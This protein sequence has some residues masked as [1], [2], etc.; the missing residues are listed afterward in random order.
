MGQRKQIGNPAESAMGELNGEEIQ[1]IGHW[2]EHR[3]SDMQDRKKTANSHI[4]H[5]TLRVRIDE[6]EKVKE[7]IDDHLLNR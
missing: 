2:I 6:L 1:E 4:E 7:K 5:E 3:V